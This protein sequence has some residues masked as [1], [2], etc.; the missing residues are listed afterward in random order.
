MYFYLEQ[1]TNKNTT[2]SCYVRVWF[3]NCIWWYL[4][5]VSF[6]YLYY[7]ITFLIMV[8]KIAWNRLDVV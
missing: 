4:D 3:L 7:G 8:F 6:C 2:T 1:N 5:M